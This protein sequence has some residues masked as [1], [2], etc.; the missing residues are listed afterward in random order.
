MCV[1]FSS[2]DVSHKVQTT[3]SERVFH[4]S[5]NIRKQ[6]S[7]GSSLRM[8]ITEHQVF[9]AFPGGEMLAQGKD[10]L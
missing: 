7:L 9:A 8:R 5:V 6:L 1:A 2:L 10:N 4:Q 3:V